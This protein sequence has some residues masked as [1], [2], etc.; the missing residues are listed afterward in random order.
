MPISRRQCPRDTKRLEHPVKYVNSS[1]PTAR[2]LPLLDVKCMEWG[3]E[4]PVCG[5]S[6]WY[7]GI[8]LP[9]AWILKH[10][11]NCKNAH[12]EVDVDQS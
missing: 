1:N 8:N 6:E 7:D 10:G 2:T 12:Q 3:W 11:K 5:D 9:W 4:C